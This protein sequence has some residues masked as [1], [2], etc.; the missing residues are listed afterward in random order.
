MA[1]SDILG[2]I[3]QEPDGLTRR[4][5]TD[6]MHKAQEQMAAW[7]RDVVPGQAVLSLDVRHSNDTVRRERTRHILE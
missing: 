2:A 4:F 1:R 6:A 7:M 3:G 5:A